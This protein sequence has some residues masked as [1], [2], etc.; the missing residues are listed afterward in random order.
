M[1]ILE[2]SNGKRAR[3]SPSRKIGKRQ[4]GGKEEENMNTEIADVLMKL[5][6]PGTS[7]SK[8]NP[9]GSTVS[10]PIISKRVKTRLQVS[11]RISNQP[12]VEIPQ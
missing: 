2:S 6:T 5:G 9:Q 1:V 10:I 11:K 3:S 12:L 7:Y 8:E 4:K